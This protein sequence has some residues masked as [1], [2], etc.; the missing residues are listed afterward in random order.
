MPQ[1]RRKIQTDRIKLSTIKAYLQMKT[2][3]EIIQ[4]Q[5]L[6]KIKFGDLGD[7]MWVTGNIKIAMDEYS[8]EV[9]IGFAEWML[10]EAIIPRDINWF[11]AGKHYTSEQLFDLYLDHLKQQSND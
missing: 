11:D 1:N 6:S 3:D 4:E 10:K 5:I 8:K 9:A 7:T 2:K